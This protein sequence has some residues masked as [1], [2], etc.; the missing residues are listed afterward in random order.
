[1]QAWI[2]FL[3]AMTLKE[4]RARYKHATLGFLWVIINPLMQMFALGFVFQFFVP[5]QVDNYFLFLFSGLLP[6]TFFSMSLNKAT[7]SIVYERS[8]IQKSKFP[9]EVIPLSIIFSNFFHMSISF[10]LLGLLLIADKVIFESYTLVATIQYILRFL[11]LIP[12]L[13]WLV[14]FTS[15]VSLLTATLNVR[16]RDIYFMV[17]ALLPLWFY[18]TPV[19]Y[20]LEL[21][22]EVFYP[23]LYLNPVTGVVELV[24]F[25]FLRL[26]PASWELLPISFLIGLVGVYLGWFLFTRQEKWFDDWV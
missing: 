21:L 6:W 19:I 10:L 9:R 17:Q 14:I 25:I 3:L 5:V 24:H 1:M 7:P 20:T 12:V 15:G 18:A 22:P 16:Y 2:E 26:E 11:L 13:S 23:I 8:L 4:I